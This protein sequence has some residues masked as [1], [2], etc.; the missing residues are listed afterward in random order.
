MLLRRAHLPQ[1]EVFFLGVEHAVVVD[2]IAATANERARLQHDLLQ[3]E[4]D[5][6]C[7][8]L[9]IIRV[10]FSQVSHRPTDANM[11][12][13]HGARRVMWRRFHN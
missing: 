8:R 12:R 2:D 11:S 5:L 9:G 6:L 1:E 7:A 4:I 3:K 10:C 13:R